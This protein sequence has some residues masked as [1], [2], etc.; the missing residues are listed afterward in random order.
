MGTFTFGVSVDEVFL[1]VT[2]LDDNV[3]EDEE[4]VSI[5][6]SFN[7]GEPPHIVTLII[8]DNDGWWLE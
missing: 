8:Q 4:E 5:L 3:A 6:I 2:I 1:P 7:N